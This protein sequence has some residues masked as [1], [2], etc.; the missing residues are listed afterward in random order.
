MELHGTQSR[1]AVNFWPALLDVVT[2]AFMVFVLATYLQLVMIMD[3]S[4]DAGDAEAARVR[5]LEAQFVAQLHHDLAEDLAAGNLEVEQALGLVHIRFA[6]R[7]LFDSADYKLK[8]SGRELL[9]RFGRFLASAWRPG[10]RRVQV[11][12]H[13]DSV[14]FV[15]SRHAKYPTNN[16]ELSSARATVVTLYLLDDSFGLPVKL[17]SA[18]GYAGNRPIADN[19][20]ASGRARN[21]RVEIELVFAGE[22]QR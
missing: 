5:S 6:D 4:T 13:T 15:A 12:G 14:P 8:S 16:W 18:N 20:S 3:V 19:V 2:A 22:E 11:E 21:R 10:V 9:A 1:W 17:I 7:V